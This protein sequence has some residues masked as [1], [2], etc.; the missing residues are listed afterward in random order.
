MVSRKPSVVAFGAHPDD[1][2]IGM[3]GTIAKLSAQGYDVNLVV[4]DVAELCRDR[5]KRGTA[6]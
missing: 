6:K 5:Q 4:A 1:I 2:E 3:G